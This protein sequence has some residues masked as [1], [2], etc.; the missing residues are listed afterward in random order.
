MPEVRC[1]EPRQIALSVL[2]Y[3]IFTCNAASFV[4]GLPN[5][6]GDHRVMIIKAPFSNTY[7]TT[8]IDIEGDLGVYTSSGNGPW[9]KQ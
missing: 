4:V 9:S 2:D 5:E 8:A 6:L 7:A 3:G 1:L